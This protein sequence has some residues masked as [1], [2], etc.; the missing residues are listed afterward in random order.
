LDRKLAFVLGG[1]GAR[2]ALQVGALRAL[3]EAGCHPDLVTGTSIGS[4]NG[5]FLAVHGFTLPGVQKL[6][7]VW[8][9]TV[10]QD[11]MPTN[12]W[13]QTMRAFFKRS[14]GLSQQRVR[15]FAISNG[16][17]PELRFKDLQTVMLYPVAADLNAGVPVIFGVDPEESVLESVL[18]SMALPPWLAP[19]EK[20]GRYLIDGGAV[21]NLPIETALLQGAAEIIAL[22]LFDPNGVDAPSLYGLG[23]FLLKLDKTVENRQI[24]LEME[25]AEARGVRVRRIC[26]T[27]EKPVPLWDF[28]Q[29]VELIERGYRLANEAIAAWPVE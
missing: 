5:A 25:L 18:A 23:D 4:A 17:T 15:E 8:R 21:S 11:L 1:G 24:Q 26:L 13:W 19:A 6:E 7:Q 2:G 14:P 12:L 29:G 22:D 10:D 27:G 16:L 3:L 9:S 20:D 28:R